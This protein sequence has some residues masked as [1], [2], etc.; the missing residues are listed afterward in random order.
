MKNKLTNTTEQ[1]E[2]ESKEKDREENFQKRTKEERRRK[3]L[4][5]PDCSQFFRSDLT[6]EHKGNSHR[7]AGNDDT[8]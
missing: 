8:Y 3:E 2:M 4:V 6:L 5:I 1:R 7:R